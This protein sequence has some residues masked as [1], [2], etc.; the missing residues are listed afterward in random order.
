[1]HEAKFVSRKKNRKSFILFMS[2]NIWLLAEC[3]SLA[4][5]YFVR[6]CFWGIS[7]WRTLPKCNAEVFS[8]SVI[9]NQMP[10]FSLN[11]FLDHRSDSHRM[12]TMHFWRKLL[13]MRRLNAVYMLFGVDLISLA[14]LIRREFLP[15]SG[16]TQHAEVR[17]LRASRV[18]HQ[19]VDSIWRSSYIAK[20]L[21]AYFNKPWNYLT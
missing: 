10:P 20:N 18:V 2:A 1:M 16:P 3:V 21:N 8:C 5:I 14:K 19:R 15:K 9:L 17:K 4:K 6:V 13:C 12:T 7:C 11:C